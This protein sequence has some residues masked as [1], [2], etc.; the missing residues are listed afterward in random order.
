ML[1]WN[2]IT[3][4]SWLAP[5]SVALLGA[6]YAL[7]FVAIPSRDAAAQKAAHAETLAYFAH[8][9]AFDAAGAIIRLEPARIQIEQALLAKRA[10]A[11]LSEDMQVEASALQLAL[12]E[13][14]QGDADRIISSAA[15][16]YWLLD[17]AKA[18]LADPLRQLNAGLLFSYLEGARGFDEDPDFWRMLSERPRQLLERSGF[19][20]PWELM[21]PPPPTQYMN[22][23]L[24]AGV[25]VPPPWGDPQ[26]L[27]HGLQEP[28]FVTVDTPEAEV[29]VY[30]SQKPQGL[31]MALP[32]ST[33]TTISTL[34]IVCQG[35]VSS[36]VC[37]WDN[38]IR[39]VKQPIQKDQRRPISEFTGGD[40][41]TFGGENCSD[42]HAGF[43]AFVVHPG[44]AVDLTQL[45]IDMQPSTWYSPM[46]SPASPQNPGPDTALAGLPLGT[47]AVTLYDPLW[48]WFPW[49]RT[50]SVQEQSCV[51]CHQLPDVSKT[52]LYCGSVLG[53][54]V[55][56]TMPP[57]T[58]G[59]HAGWERISSSADL[60]FEKH[61]NALR[62]ACGKAPATRA[63]SAATWLP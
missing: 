2:P 11:L 3:Y 56:F 10:L 57:G 63:I 42:C 34:Q 28:R 12:G 55:D 44:S 24:A 8:G 20:W 36:R 51:S 40:N 58:A 39:G 31:C 61:V 7:S 26:W 5:L 37:F 62:K 49:W 19:R 38:R 1:K 33:G 32:R 35:K 41:I 17:H 47:A 30:R 16:I 52:P 54:A 59:I 60:A 50:F 45:G 53:N 25:P 9:Q 13:A 23:C 15:L 4:A 48:G 6:V 46:I 29:F 21:P 27:S 43:N 14:A 22:D 18:S